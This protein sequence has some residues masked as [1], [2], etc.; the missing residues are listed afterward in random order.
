[1][2]IE[3]LIEDLLE[4]AQLRMGKP[5]DLRRARTDLAALARQ[6]VASHQ[7]LSEG[8]PFVLEG[9]TDE[10]AG[11]WDAE[12]LRR[13]LANLL[14][15]AV[16]YSPHDGEISMHLAREDEAAGSWAVLTVQDHGLGI[17]AAEIAHVFE[18]F[19]RGANVAGHIAG[20]GIGLA[21]AKDIVERHG[22]AITIESQEG[23]GTTVTVRLPVGEGAA[24]EG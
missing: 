9:A 8:R 4:M 18:R 23:S 22:G 10:M 2:Q 14:D 24:T 16:K 3:T 17:P 19:R 13:M 5:F 11:W 6:A 20:S 1:V 15:N 21:S 12:R 7:Q